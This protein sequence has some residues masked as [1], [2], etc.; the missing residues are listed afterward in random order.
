M[1]LLP[2][3]LFAAV[4]LAASGCSAAGP[5]REEQATIAVHELCESLGDLRAH[6]GELADLDGTRAGVLD[7]RDFRQD[8]SDD[9]HNVRE[10]ARTVRHP[11]AALANAF[12]SL[13][14]AVDILPGDATG[15]RATE[16]IMPQ[17]QAL[18]RAVAASQASVKC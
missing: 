15:A 13:S 7:V 14:R 2:V 12:D 9:L 1:P 3:C 17:L 11:T 6:T 5:T 18:D 4:S 16:Q 10:E 8:I